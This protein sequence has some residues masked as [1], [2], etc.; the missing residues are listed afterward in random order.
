LCELKEK[1]MKLTFSGFVATALF[2]AMGAVAMAQTGPGSFPVPSA[3]PPNAGPA[4]RFDNGYLD[5]HPDVAQ[6][7]VANPRLAND[8][9]YLARHP[10][11][12]SYLANHPQVRTDLAQHPERFMHSASDYG[13]PLARFDDGYLD[14]HPEVAKQLAR[15]PELANNA[16]YLAHHPELQSY[17]ANHPQVRTELQKHPKGF[18]N[19][20]R[21]YERVDR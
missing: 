5:H 19:R 15:H 20:V 11:L 21:Q 8:P 13:A 12:Q 2:S 4:A 16:D 18:M 7:L 17:L 6:Q 14:H 9:Q 1:K 10:E 3:M